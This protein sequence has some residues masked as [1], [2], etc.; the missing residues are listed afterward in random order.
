MRNVFL[1]N[2]ALPSSIMGIGDQD[3]KLSALQDFTPNPRSD[4][5][6]ALPLYRVGWSLQV[7]LE[8]SLK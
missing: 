4:D 8:S 1:A 2:D 5:T 6:G 3:Y 7:I